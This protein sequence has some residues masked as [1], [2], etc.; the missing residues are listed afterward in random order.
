[1]TNATSIVT[2]AAPGV[3]FHAPA[4]RKAMSHS[5]TMRYILGDKVISI[6][7]EAG[8]APNAGE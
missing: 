5:R 2:P 3:K 4:A 6:H 8:P 7:F 1:M